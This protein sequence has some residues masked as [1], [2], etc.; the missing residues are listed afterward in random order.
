MDL[1]ISIDKGLK[2]EKEHIDSRCHNNVGNDTVALYTA[3]QD[4]S[5][6]HDGV[7]KVLSA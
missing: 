6:E 4:V 1:D 3:I 7:R 5:S 2:P